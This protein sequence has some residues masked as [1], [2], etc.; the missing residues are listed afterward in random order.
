MKLLFVCSGNICRSPMAEGIAQRMA[1]DLRLDLE[2]ASAGTLGLIDRP[3]DPKAVRVCREIGVDLRGHRSQALRPDLVQWA[4]LVF[5]ME[6]HHAAAVQRTH[7][8]HEPAL[9]M[10]G[11]LVGLPLIPDPIGGWIWDFRRARKQIESALGMWATR[12]APRQT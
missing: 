10:M 8:I 4:D 7:P 2:A 9:V 12:H 6:P 3:A 1:Q 5:V 11:P